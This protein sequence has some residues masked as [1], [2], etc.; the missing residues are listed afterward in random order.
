MLE[1]GGELAIAS[2]LDDATLIR[3]SADAEIIIVR[4]LLPPSLF[5]LSPRLRA[6][7][8]HGAGLDMIPVDAATKAGVLVANVPG[9]NAR[10]V[11][12]HVIMVAMAL[13]RRFRAMDHDL[14]NGGWLKGRAHADLA[15]ELSGKTVGIVGMGNVGR[16]VA[17]IAMSGFGL[18]VIANSRR[19]GSLPPG[20]GFRGIDA[21]V[22][23]A[24]ILVLC[25]PLTSETR[26]LIDAE[27]IAQMKPSAIIVNV[28][29]GPVIDDGALLAAL[30]E[31]RI[32]GA[33]LDVFATQPLPPEHPYFSFP[34]VILTPH[35]AGITEESMERMGTGAA[36]E[37]LRV[38]SGGLP[39]SFINPEVTDHYR[40][41]FP[42][43]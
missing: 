22:S 26:G 41:R 36:A 7:I 8:R 11:A 17:A 27:R 30:A 6:A 1:E 18:N 37:A 43:V 40:R 25:C 33:A 34:N 10:S 32:A 42:A 16:T 35:L 14:R 12:E 13:L 5:E 4:A 24:D 15:H 23:E 38:L 9:V 3:E 19:A 20:V 21:L 29:R 28:A 39:V 31:E 2:G